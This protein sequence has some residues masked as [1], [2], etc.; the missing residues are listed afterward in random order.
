MIAAA[1]AC[2]ASCTSEPEPEALESG[3][4]MQFE[5]MEA[6][7]SRTVITTSNNITNKPFLVFGDVNRT[8]VFYQGLQK[9]FMGDTVT[10]VNKTWDYETP[11]YW[12]MGQE[13][14]FVAIHPAYIQ[15][16][17]E[18]NID[19]QDSK[20]SFT[21]ETPTD[22]YKEST[23]ILVATH[24]RKYTRDNAGA[25]KF[26]FK[27]ILTR[28]NIAPAI[29]E[30]L[31]YED[32]KDKI[33]YPYNENEYILIHR[34]ELYGLKTKAEFS[35]APVPFKPGE[36]NTDER[37]ETYNLDK[38]SV[39]PIILEFRDDKIKVTNNKQNVAVFDDNNALLLL[40][41]TIG[42]D[43]YAILYYTVNGDHTEKDLIRKITLPLSGISEWERGKS[44]T[45]KF[46]IQKVYTGQI[47][48]GSLKWTIND[49]TI[50]DPD[51]TDEW[52]KYG[53]T[54]SQEFEVD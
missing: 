41:Q 36:V 19:Y 1:A 48:P 43:V 24:R 50:T 9:I 20:V 46:S 18:K 15:E 37:L 28:L 10:Y 23:D 5:A 30:V 35:F 51:N 47:K 44:Y 7:A 3:E 45:Y 42:E 33:K 22:K 29:D 54:I 38:N 2:A 25:V 32:E 53:E 40:P 11:I 4:E 6:P 27:H 13:H 8:G 16:I 26:G 34:I 21:Y 14:S 17:P 31:M 12:L 49:M 52:I 39:K